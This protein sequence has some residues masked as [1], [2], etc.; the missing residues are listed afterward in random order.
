M[1][2]TPQKVHLLFLAYFLVSLGLWLIPAIVR[3]AAPSNS[4][5]PEFESYVLWPHNATFIQAPLFAM[6]SPA[7]LLFVFS[8]LYAWGTAIDWSR[9]NAGR[10]LRISAYVFAICML[11]AVIAWHTLIR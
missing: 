2:L 11:A 3:I 6:L 7:R 5:E 1:K 9:T 10:A 8:A 4:I